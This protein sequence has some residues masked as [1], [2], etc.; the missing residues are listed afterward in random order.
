MFADYKLADLKNGITLLKEGDTPPK[1]T[2]ESGAV[3]LEGMRKKWGDHVIWDSRQKAP[4]AVNRDQV[5][6]HFLDLGLD[7][8]LEGTVEVTLADGQKVPCRT[9]F[10]VTKELLDGSYTPADVEKL[11]WAPAEAVR[12]LLPGKSPPTRKKPCLPWAWGQ[13]SSS[14]AISRTGPCFWLRP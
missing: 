14:I 9:V 11:T 10:D 2:Q 3:V 5:D 4:V 12:S 13:T 6:R 1:G 8:M 7:P